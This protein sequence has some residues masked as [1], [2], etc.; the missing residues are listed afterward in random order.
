MQRPWWTAGWTWTS[1]RLSW[2]WRLTPPQA[3]L[4]RLKQWVER[5]DC[6]CSALM[7]THLEYWV[8]FSGHSPPPTKK[9]MLT[10]WRESRRLPPRQWAGWRIKKK[11]P[12]EAERG[13]LVSIAEGKATGSWKWHKLIKAFYYWKVKVTDKSQPDFPELQS[14]KEGGRVDNCH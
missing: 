3:A 13:R 4:A 11:N 1:N 9:E 7:Q 2:Q 12:R 5:S 10:N 6:L 8:W 14:K